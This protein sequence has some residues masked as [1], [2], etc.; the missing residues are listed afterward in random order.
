MN[1][2]LDIYNAINANA[3]T[4]LNSNIPSASTA[5]WQTPTTIMDPR[6]FKFG[7]QFDF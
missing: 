1:V 4:A 6:L 7:A 3:V 5:T 2:H